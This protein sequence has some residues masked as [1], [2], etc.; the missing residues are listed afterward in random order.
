MRLRRRGGRRRRRIR[1]RRRRRR[2]R[3]IAAEVN[4]F[5]KGRFNVEEKGGKIVKGMK[6]GTK[7][8]KRK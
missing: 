8:N 5:G 4:I 3:G 7:G 1:R 2:R 6:R